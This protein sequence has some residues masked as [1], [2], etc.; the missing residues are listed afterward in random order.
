MLYSLSCWNSWMSGQHIGFPVSGSKRGT[1]IGC[2]LEF[3]PNFETGIQ[4]RKTPIW[5]TFQEVSLTVSASCRSTCRGLH[6]VNSSLTPFSARIQ[7]KQIKVSLWTRRGL[8]CKRCL[9]KHLSDI[10]S[11]CSQLGQP[12]V[13]CLSRFCPNFF[14]L[15]CILTLC[16]VTL[17]DFARLFVS[18]PPPLLLWPVHLSWDSADWLSRFYG[19]GECCHCPTDS[20]WFISS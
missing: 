17:F 12:F 10:T 2:V 9:F 4:K 5:P 13:L 6:S 11:S 14:V 8:S 18:P 1:E 15:L 16:S 3:Y 19:G 20:C 7:L